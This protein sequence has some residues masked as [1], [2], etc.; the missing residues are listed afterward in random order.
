[1]GAAVAG[2]VDS[3]AAQEAADAAAKATQAGIYTYTTL[4][5]DSE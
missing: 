5:T 2:G 3:K 1:M 4:L